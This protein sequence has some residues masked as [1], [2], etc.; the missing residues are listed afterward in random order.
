VIAAEVYFAAHPE[1]ELSDIEWL[2]YGRYLH[3]QAP[4]QANQYTTHRYEFY[5]REVRVTPDA[6]IPRPE[7][8]YKGEVSHCSCGTLRCWLAL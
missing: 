3:E 7:T 8:E 4:G 6:L 5:G 2:H 1:G